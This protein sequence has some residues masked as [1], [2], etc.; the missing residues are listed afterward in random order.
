[1]SQQLLL[2]FD[3]FDQTR[4]DDDAETRAAAG[5]TLLQLWTAE[6]ATRWAL[7]SVNDAAKARNWLS[8]T[9]ALGHGPAESHFLRTA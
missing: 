9:R 6:G 7:F 8:E 1:M 4:F 3:A 5:L 2:R